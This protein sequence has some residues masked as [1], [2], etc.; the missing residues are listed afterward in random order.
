[1]AGFDK[2][3][4]RESIDSEI[5]ACFEKRV[6]VWLTFVAG[7]IADDKSRGI[8]CV[9]EFA[10]DG[11]DLVVNLCSEKLGAERRVGKPTSAMANVNI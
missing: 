8:E 9:G 6:L 10:R 4:D 5:T 11:C 2:V 7:E 3:I 1:M